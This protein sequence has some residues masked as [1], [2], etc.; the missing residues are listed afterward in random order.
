MPKRWIAWSFADI[1]EKSSFYG[2]IEYAIDCVY[3]R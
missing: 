2:I 3:N 1:A